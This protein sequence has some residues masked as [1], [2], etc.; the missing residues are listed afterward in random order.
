MIFEEMAAMVR[1]HD[2]LA[3]RVTITDWN[4]SMRVEDGPGAGSTYR[5]LSGEARGAHGLSPSFWIY[6]ELAQA[7]NR[8]LFDNL[9]T[10]MGKQEA[11]LG[12]IISTQAA[13]D[14]HPLSELIDDAAAHTDRS[15][16]VQCLSA[17][18]DA[19]VFDPA[20]IR[21]VNPALGLFLN[22][23]DVFAEAERARRLPGAQSAF[24]NT[25]LNQRIATHAGDQFLNAA[26]WDKGAGPIDESLSEKRDRP[27]YGGLDLASTVDL[28]ALV[29]AAADD[30]GVVH[31]KP[32]AWT[33]QVGLNERS[34]RDAVPYNTW[35]REGLLRTTPG[36]AIDYEWIAAALGEIGTRSNLVR[37][38]YDRHRINYLK[39]DLAKQGVIL[40]L[41][42]CGQ[43]YVSMSPCLE[44]FEQLAANGRL[45]H[46]GHPVLTWCFTHAIVLRDPAGNRKLDKSRRNT[47]I[48]LAVAAVM[49]VG[50][51]RAAPP[52]EIAAMIA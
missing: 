19:D 14:A 33:P 3:R 35:V 47:R 9:M 13:D 4:K 52:V 45:R 44:T 16:L 6:D 21:S 43:G 20:V 7:R 5:A 29:L 28:S 30:D 22:E 37:L 11:C 12:M 48:D 27:V 51:M 42:E 40:P 10:G 41:A 49:A 39:Q 1:A 25:R 38:A 50:G 8:V 46:G 36:E 18:I 17:P 26:V 34:D 23:G 24:R 32:Y 15:L 31:L 2:D